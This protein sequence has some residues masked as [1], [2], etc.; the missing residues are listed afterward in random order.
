[1]KSKPSFRPTEVE[2]ITIGDE[3][4][5]GQIIDTNSPWMAQELNKIG[6]K[7]RYITTVADKEQEILDA[8]SLAAGRVGIILITGGLGPTKDD[9]TKHALCKY[10]DTALRFDE[11]SFLNVQKL[12]HARGREVTEI[13]RKQAEVPDVC[14]PLLNEYGTAPGMLFKMEER[15]YVSMPGV[16][17][18][19]K[20]IMRNH[21]LPE[22]RSSF[23]LPPVLHETILT[24]GIGESFL[25]ELIAPWEDNLPAHIRLAYLPSAGI[26]RLRLTAS[27]FSEEI[28]RKELTEQV[29]ALKKLADKY[30]FGRETDTLEKLLGDELRNKKLSLATAESCTGGYIAHRITSVPGSSD[31]YIGS[32]IAYDNQIKISSLNVDQ[33]LLDQHG[34]VSEQVVIAMALGVK[35]RFNSDFAIATS[36]IAGPSGATPDKPLGTVWVAIAGPDKIFSKKYLLGTDRFNVI[37]STCLYSFHELLKILKETD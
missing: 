31:Y 3:I 2:I 25:S 33:N 7:V 9:I 6:L 11:P 32:I 22:L 30:I 36:G 23:T 29:S 10:F 34:A 28:L 35:K 5:I 24:Q 21:V 20:G 15:I 1:M 12:F 14:Q 17:H 37:Q 8:L 27:G 18:E 4:L 19:M 16:P 13:N 26:L